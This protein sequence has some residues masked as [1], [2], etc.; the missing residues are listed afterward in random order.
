[1]TQFFKPVREVSKW[2]DLIDKLCE[3]NL[4]K[5]PPC[6]PF[7]IG[8]TAIVWK[9]NWKIFGLFLGFLSSIVY[10]Q[11][12][13]VVF[14]HQFVRKNIPA[15]VDQFLLKPIIGGKKAYQKK[16]PC[17]I[18]LNVKKKKSRQKRLKF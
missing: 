7:I 14:R 6:S 4:T 16:I 1:L 8:A 11:R 18:I 15:L 2:Y 12:F 5:K 17:V 10:V 9:S 13:I 3:T